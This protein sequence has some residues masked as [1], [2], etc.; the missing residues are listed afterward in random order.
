MTRKNTK[1]NFKDIYTKNHLRNYFIAGLLIIIG[2]VQFSII[3]SNQ[4]ELIWKTRSSSS[5]GSDTIKLPK[6][7][8]NYFFILE[9]QHLVIG[10]DI[11]WLDIEFLHL[12][13][14]ESYIFDLVISSGLMAGTYYDTVVLNIPSGRYSISWNCSGVIANYKLSLYIEGIFS[15]GDPNFINEGLFIIMSSVIFGLLLIGGIIALGYGVYHQRNSKSNSPLK[16]GKVKKTTSK[17]MVEKEKLIKT[18]I[19]M[20]KQQELEI[21]QYYINKINVIECPNCGNSILK[22]EEIICAICGFK[23][24]EK[25]G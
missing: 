17:D 14:F 21:Q 7:S 15:N 2:V 20:K 24:K 22:K 16:S 18:L 1:F 10:G 6:T 3:I 9:I 11:T 4:S 8:N 13:T 5:T 19:S 25:E 12:G 23:L